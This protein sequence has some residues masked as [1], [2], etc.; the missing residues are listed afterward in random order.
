MVYIFLVAAG[1][2]TNLHLIVVQSKLLMSCI[3]SP[4]NL[5]FLRLSD[6]AQNR[7]H[8][9]DRRT[10]GLQHFSAP[11]RKHQPVRGFPPDGAQP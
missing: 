1:F 4:I 5:K 7:G 11:I 8:G 3:M 9:T 6:F 2:F 10:D